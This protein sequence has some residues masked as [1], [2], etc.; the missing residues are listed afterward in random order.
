MSDLR[1]EFREP[2][3]IYRG[4]RVPVWEG[5]R[6]VAVRRVTDED[7]K[8]FA[9]AMQRLRSLLEKVSNLASNLGLSEVERLNLLADVIVVF[10]K[11]P[12]IQEVTPVAP[13]PLKAHALL[14]LAPKLRKEF[15]SE[16][17]YEFARQLASFRVE[18]LGFAKELFEQ[19]TVNLVYRLWIAFPADTR[20]GHNT[21]SLIA[22][23]LMTSAIAWAL[24]REE[25]KVRGDEE[26]RI[27]LAALLHDLGK[28]VDP[29]RHY[30]ASEKLARDLLKG[31][32]DEGTLESI[33]TTIR[34]H[35]RK[36]GPSQ[37]L[38]EADRLASASDRLENIVKDERT[39]GS[40]LTKIRDLIGKIEDE[41][42][43][44]R[45]VYEKRGKLVEAGLVR[46]DPIKELTEEFLAKVSAVVK[47]LKGE[48]AEPDISLVLVDVA[49]IQD[50]IFR[51]QEIRIVAAASHLIELLVHAHF[52]EYLR[53][54][55]LHIPPEAV[56][57]AGGGNILLLLP[58]GMTIDAEKLAREYGEKNGFKLVVVS[59]PFCDS[60]VAASKILANKMFV[61]KHEVE[62][63][64]SLDLPGLSGQ[65]FC[66]TCYGDWAQSTIETPEGPRSVCGICKKLYN[67][68]SDIHFKSKWEA[69][70]NVAGTSFKA[71]DAFNV[72]WEKVSRWI[73]EVIAGHD[74][75]EL[76]EGVGRV[77]DYAIVKFDGNAIGS[78]MLEAIS[79]TDAIERSSRIDMAMKK[80][81]FKALEALY[82]GI[83]EVVG[84]DKA[85]REV[86]RVVLG[87]IYMGGDDGFVLTPS[88]IAVPF[89]HFI[90]E[91]FSRQLGLERG[92]KVAVAAGPAK[93]N[94]WALLDC[95][96]KMME[97]AGSVLRREDPTTKEVL[98]A[99]AFDIFEAGSPS[100]ASA[101]ERMRRFSRRARG[102]LKPHDENIDRQ[103][104]YF[105]KRQDLEGSTIPELWS[106]LVPLV[107]GVAP[108]NKWSDDEA[109]GAYVE[110]FKRAYLA[111]RT[112][113][114]EIRETLSDVRNAILR[115]WGVV[116]GSK[117]WREK[118]LVY[119]CRQMIRGE[120]GSSRR[121][122][123]EKAYKSLAEFVKKSL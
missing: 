96:S 93:M 29:E 34:E 42:A 64:D 97:E 68:G 50:F 5:G 44:W 6:P 89:A 66:R 81:Y 58:K 10:F 61:K 108:P 15:W 2:Y 70:I 95:A 43:F 7:R 113:K 63:L 103:Q 40:K 21:S 62:L 22:H 38:S 27:R 56:I 79:F 32:V 11:A 88:W 33:A 71:L 86:A 72:G 104:P 48:V 76:Q 85:R 39:I 121:D 49:S 101:V 30:E 1:L 25:G 90:A 18:E 114:T 98:G 46:D 65:D 53:N 47:G 8:A 4:L 109:F 105:I 102:E 94:I 106:S 19:E 55:G 16:D 35:H 69:T 67:V 75:E 84:H 77:R 117:Y 37:V 119:L 78:F 17:L 91:E 122:A 51:G 115:S 9:E 123:M 45:A 60:Y 107:L 57:Y 112:E 118:L 80:A 100:G 83:E 54:E 12:L 92:L 116:S 31:L 23:S 41:W 59:A 87:T 74:P 24:R 99:I 3:P 110:A 26:A 52:L 28:A 111:S 120:G 73:I 82:K 14:L 20:P 36:A 13:T